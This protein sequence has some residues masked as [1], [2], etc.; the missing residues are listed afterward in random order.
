[1]HPISRNINSIGHVH[2]ASI[3]IFKC[4]I[5]S[6]D[7]RECSLINNWGVC[8]VKTPGDPR[9][10][11]QAFFAIKGPNILCL[12]APPPRE[13][14]ESLMLPPWGGVNVLLGTFSKPEVAHKMRTQAFFAIKGPNILCLPTPP[15]QECSE[16][17]TPPLWGGVSVLLGTFSA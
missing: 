9:L 5:G 15:P 14:S 2:P 17:L 4:K 11:T 16:C 8:V 10:W 13:C 7:V 6:T 1:M 3:I 12:P